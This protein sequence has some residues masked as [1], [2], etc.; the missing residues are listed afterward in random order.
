LR[1]PVWDDDP[2]NVTVTRK[3]HSVDR[4]RLRGLA[5][6][7]FQGEIAIWT[8]RGSRLI[9]FS[10][11]E[12]EAFQVSAFD[13]GVRDGLPVGA[14]RPLA[15]R[16]TEGV[17]VVSGLVIERLLEYRLRP[18]DD[19]EGYPLRLQPNEWFVLGDN[20]PVSVDSREWGPLITSQLLGRIQSRQPPVRRQ[21]IAVESAV[22][23]DDRDSR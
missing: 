15:L 13:G 11:I 8:S 23:S 12:G 10:F 9:P 17:A 18:H 7:T 20:V 1:S 3:L 14:T 21:V 4:L 5:H 22:R 6:T 16:T 2:F 19:R